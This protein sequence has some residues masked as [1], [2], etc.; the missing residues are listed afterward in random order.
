MKVSS[1]VAAA[2]A[3]G[4]W[5]CTTPTPAAQTPSVRDL[6]RQVR[7]SDPQLSPDGKTVAVIETRADLDSDEFRSEI[8]KSSLPTRNVVRNLSSPLSSGLG[9]AIAY[10]MLT[11]SGLHANCDTPSLPLV[12][13]SASPPPIGS[14]KSCPFLSA[15]WAM[16]PMPSPEGDQRG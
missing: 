5:F 6:V 15:S 11:P 13:C 1:S 16:K 2:A 12:S 8:V 3:V 14:T 4:L 7:L 10:A 9:S